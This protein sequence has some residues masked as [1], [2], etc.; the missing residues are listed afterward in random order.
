MSL[1]IVTVSDGFGSETVPSITDPVATQ[2][3]HHTLTAL[4]ISRGYVTLSVAPNNPNSG[5]LSWM[6]VGQQ[7]G[8]DFDITG[9][10][11]NFLPKLLSLMSPS[12]YITLYYQ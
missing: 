5:I 12:D 8:A 1:K 11:L 3:F 2:V 6:G 4:D 10:R 9:V 7:Y